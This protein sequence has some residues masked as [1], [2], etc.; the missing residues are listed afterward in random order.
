MRSLIV[1]EVYDT[2][3]DASCIIEVLRSFHVVEPL[4][5]YY[6]VHSFG[7]CIICRVLILSHSYARVYT[8]Q[9]CHV[10][11]AAV[12]NPTIRVVRHQRE[13]HTL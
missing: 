8:L 4:L 1:V 3:N 7:D 5:L 9:P 6:S 10:G 13:I 11:V 2:S 12:L